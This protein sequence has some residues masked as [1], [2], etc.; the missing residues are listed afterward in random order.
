MRLSCY[1]FSFLNDLSD[2]KMDVRQMD[3]F[4]TGSF[5]SVVDKGETFSFSNLISAL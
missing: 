1:C 4:Q 3:E 2:I 5:D